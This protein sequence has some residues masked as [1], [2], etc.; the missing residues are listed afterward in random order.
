MRPAPS[1]SPKP[2]RWCSTAKREGRHGRFAPLVTDIDEGWL[3]EHILNYPAEVVGAAWDEGISAPEVVALIARM[4]TEGKLSSTVNKGGALSLQLEVDRKTLEGH[5][6]TL[7]DG[8][9]F[10]GR[11]QTSTTKRGPARIRALRRQSPHPRSCDRHRRAG[12]VWIRVGAGLAFRAHVHWGLRGAWACVSPALFAS[13]AA[14]YFLWFVA[15][16]GTVEASLTLIAGVVT[17]ALA[18]LLGSI[19]AMSS[20]QPREGAAFRK[21]LAS[22]REFFISELKKDQPALRDEW[23]PWILAFG[24]SHHVDQWSTRAGSQGSTR[25]SN[26][27]PFTASSSS[28]SSGSSPESFGGFTGGRSGGAGG[29]AAWVSAASV[30]GS[31]CV[32]AQFQRIE[33]QQQFEQQFFVGRRRGWRMVAV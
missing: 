5:E 3:R 17:A 27:T 26:G 2:R 15:G 8:L 25:R 31:E 14:L 9:F 18:V 19:D 23:F 10:G 20:R 4:V 13:M 16:P 12:V 32:A 28:S 11:T 30:D 22:G 6:R 29:G 24:L 21:K 7:V 33:R 1:V